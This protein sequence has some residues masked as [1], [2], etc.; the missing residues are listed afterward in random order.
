VADIL[1]AFN[2]GTL[3][4]ATASERLQLSRSQLYSLRHQ[5][6]A[7]SDTW[8]PTASGGDRCAPWPPEVEAFLADFLPQCDPLNCG[9]IADELAR[10]FAFVR[11]RATVAAHL[12]AHFP[13]LLPAQPPGPKPR[14]RWSCAALG[15]LFQ[16]DSSPHAW[17]LAASLQVLLLTLDDHSRRIVAGAFAADTTWEHFC[18]LRTLF[19]TG[20]LPAAFYT[21]GLSLFGHTSTADRRDTHSQFQRALTALG[22]AHRVAPDAPAKG[23]IE[24]R[25]G[26]FQRR[27]VSLF[28]YEGIRDSI[29]ANALLQ[30]QIR[31][32]NAHQ[33]C[34]TTGL[35]PNQA[36]DK[37]LEEQRSVLRPPPDAAR[38]DL[39]LALHTQRR[40]NADHTVDFL[41]CSW[42]VSPVRQRTVTLV[43]LPHRKFYVLAYAPDPNHPDRWPP[44]LATH[45]LT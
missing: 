26:Y 36:W 15:E 10:R 24:R 39:H 31:F 40:L 8:A 30:D 16:H 41:G 27:L 2:A 9:L 35:T 23:K 5:W 38:L 14:R 43:H 7:Q 3:D 28:A 12:R 18:L 13:A 42:P 44:I 19:E 37:A 32:Y 17:W 20:G 1:R 22:I 11:S 33:V 25:F 4:A 45:A 6:L 21:D 34:R 29:Q